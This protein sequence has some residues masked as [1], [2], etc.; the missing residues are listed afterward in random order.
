MIRR[1]SISLYFFFSGLIFSSWASRIPD[2][3]LNFGFNE[4]ELGAILFMLPMGALSALPFAGWVVHRFN[5]KTVTPVS[6]LLFSVFLGAVSCADTV[7][8]LSFSLFFFGVLGNLTNIAMNTQGLTVQAFL[9]KPILSS[10]HAMWSLGAFSAAAV[11]GWASGHGISMQ[12]Q[13]LLVSVLTA[14]FSVFFFYFLLPDEANPSS[15]SKVFA[16]PNRPLL[17]LGLICF[18]AAMSEGAMA[19]WSALYFKEAVPSSVWSSTA[20]Y[21]AFVFCMALGRFAGDGLVH[22]FSHKTVLKL[23]GLLVLSGMLIA[24]SLRTSLNV[25]VGFGLVGFG[26]SSVMP[27]VYMLAA[28]SRSMAPSTAL[29]AVSSVGFFGFLLGPPIIGFIAQEIGLRITLLVVSALGLL[30]FLLSHRLRQEKFS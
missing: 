25:V 13:F 26:V 21:S 12:H 1:L 5:S 19:D 27:I 18:C 20:G 10:L 22:Q 24:L 8:S 4:A 16:L 29:A 28:K 23:N 30:I 9:K 7:L 14:L 6:L 15:P 17:M 2:I 11:S 3:K